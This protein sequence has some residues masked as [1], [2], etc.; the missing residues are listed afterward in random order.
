MIHTIECNQGKA[1]REA[2]ELRKVWEQACEQVRDIMSECKKLFVCSLVAPR[3]R[4]SCWTV[5]GC[6]TGHMVFDGF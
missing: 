3:F 2:S 4:D 5:P 6:E 1:R